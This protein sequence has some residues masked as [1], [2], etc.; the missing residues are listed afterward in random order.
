MQLQSLAFLFVTWLQM[1]LRTRFSSNLHVACTWDKS[2]AI[3]GQK[4]FCGFTR[5]LIHRYTSLM[6]VP[7]CLICESLH[8]PPSSKLFWHRTM[9]FLFF[10]PCFL[11]MNTTDTWNRSSRCVSFQKLMQIV[12]CAAP[13]NWIEDVTYVKNI[14]AID[15]FFLFIHTPPDVFCVRST[16]LYVC[17]Y[18]CARWTSF[19]RRHGNAH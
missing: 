18:I 12:M 1:C 5:L 16:F 10:H 3:W 7:P 8:Q 4:M 17:V 19:H 13:P 6:S 2:W 9:C 11:P 14:Q 15:I